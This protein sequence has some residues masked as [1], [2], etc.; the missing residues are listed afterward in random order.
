MSIAYKGIIIEVSNISK[1]FIVD[2]LKV[3]V[4]LH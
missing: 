2:T 1:I 4:S 3:L